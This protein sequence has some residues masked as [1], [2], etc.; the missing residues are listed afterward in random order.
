MSRGRDLQ[1]ALPDLETL[2]LDK[3]MHTHDA[4]EGLTAFM[5]KRKPEF[6]DR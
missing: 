2:Y 4:R 6:Q 3:L 5:E 1:T